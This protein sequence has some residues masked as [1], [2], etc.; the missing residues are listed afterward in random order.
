[1]ADFDP[2]YAE[3]PFRTLVA[4]APGADVYPA[5]DFRVE[6]GPVFHR[7]RLDGSARVLVVG[8]DPAQHETILRRILVGEAGH[9]TQGFLAKLGITRGYVLVNTFLY[10]VY[11][12]GGGNKHKKTKPIAKYRNRWLAALLAP[13]KVEAVVA[14]GSLADSAWHDFLASSEGAGVNVPYRH[15]THPTRPEA[16]GGSAAAH[17]GAIKAMLTNW[18][19]A[20]EA[21]HPLG[22]PDKTGPL[23]LY[24]SKFK[25]DEKLPIPAFDAPPWA[26]EWMLSDDGWADRPGKGQAKRASI[27]V[28]VP[29]AYLRKLT[30]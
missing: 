17:A 12:Q 25:P 7:G 21:L 16:G 30:S 9:R 27:L 3:E 14:L 28:R 11:G 18:N 1:M 15:I 20:L 19:Q 2:G 29:T 4:D 13:G 22:H 24:G 23:Q 5:K 6:W 10:S 8:Q 26:P